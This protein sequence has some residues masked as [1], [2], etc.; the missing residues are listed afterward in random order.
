MIFSVALEA[1]GKLS[2]FTC[3]E[4]C[5]ASK[6]HWK[7][8]DSRPHSTYPKDVNYEWP[9]TIRYDFIAWA[10]VPEK[11]RR[12]QVS[13]GHRRQHTRPALQASGDFGGSSMG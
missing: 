13:C 12:R 3:D 10:Q 7:A 11:Q 2:R 9:L 1:S 8:C 4:V 5:K 6:W